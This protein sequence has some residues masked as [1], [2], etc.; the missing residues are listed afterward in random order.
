MDAAV[1]AQRRAID[2]AS[3]SPLRVGGARIEPA[4]RDASFGGGSERLQPQNLKVL[5]ALARRRGKVVTRD[6]LIEQCWEGRFVGDDVI[7]R[8]I[9][10]LR[11]FAERAGGFAIETVR[12]AGYRLVETS[13][14]DRTRVRQWL[15]AS[16]AA[17]LLALVALA[18]ALLDRGGHTTPNAPPTLGVLPFTAASNDA[19]AHELA[20]AAHDA[21]TNTLSQTQF[22]VRTI[23]AEASSGASPVDF[24]VSADADST[25]RSAL[26]TVR[27]EETA[28]HVIVYSHR[29]EA[30]GEG[31]SLFAERIGAQV[32][33]SIE[34][35]VPLLA[36]DR[37]GSVD[38]A[39]LQQ[40]F[41]PADSTLSDV[42]PLS[43][44]RAY[45]N[46]RSI[47][48]REPTSALAQV[49]LAFNGAFALMEVSPDQRPEIAAIA[50]HA[51]DRAQ[52]LAPFFGE[53]HVPWCLL[54]NMSAQRIACENRLRAGM[55]VDP[56][57]P[58]VDYFLA[59]RIKDA[60]RFLE[61]HD[62][63]ARSLARDQYVPAKIALQLRML[64][65]AGDGEEAQILYRRAQRWWPDHQIIFW[66]RVYGMAD[67]GDLGAIARFADES[68]R[69][70]GV[71]ARQLVGELPLA[72]RQRNL[73]A[74][75]QACPLTLSESPMRDFCMLAFAMVG[76]N[77]DAFALADKQF[78]DRV[79]RTSADQERMFLDS[80]WVVDTD[81]V[82]GPAAAPMRRDRRYLALAQRV[83]LLSYWRRGTLPDFCRPPRP[84]PVCGELK[85]H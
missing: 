6:E 11:Q 27:I 4:S 39:T 80:P 42:T 74:I 70:N 61:A 1:A 15:F 45:Q 25:G 69:A 68:G 31:V 54:H 57:S 24:L 53:S 16:G 58:W 3:E 9:S 23:Q 12:G 2:L 30:V 26:V 37:R 14:R 41:E 67:R 66:D 7:N 83:G 35:T 50:R 47:A 64:E 29:F 18:T 59:N 22:A 76:D 8:S 73:G 34:W 85:A 32:A 63:V 78:P 52:A 33:G 56:Q 40:L 51:S 44:L 81:I 48:A 36:F 75:K 60:G 43:T 10:M 65:A 46:S 49:N 71:T 77:D 55:R 19:A 21:V 20:S 79:G 5:I 82:T 72:M 13:A 62:L 28:H 38:P 84:E 17:M